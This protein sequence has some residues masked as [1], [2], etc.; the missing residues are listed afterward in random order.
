MSNKDK[1]DVRQKIGNYERELLNWLFPEDSME[2]GDERQLSEM[3]QYESQ[4][5]EW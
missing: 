4:G 2:R 5:G 3:Y 1:V